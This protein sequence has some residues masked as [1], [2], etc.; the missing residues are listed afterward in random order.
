MKTLFFSTTIHADRQKVW[1]TMLQP[2]TYKL[3]SG[4]GWPDSYYEGEWKQDADIRFCGPDQAGTLLHIDAYR[5]FEYL[6]GTHT[7]ILLKG[8]IIDK[9]SEDA[10]GWVGTKENYTFIQDGDTTTL[11]VEIIMTNPAWESMFNEGWPN[12]LKKLKELCEA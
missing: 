6:G 1:E 3:W 5:P 4:A 10:K 8:G 9:D 12:A 11:K 2:E 7:A